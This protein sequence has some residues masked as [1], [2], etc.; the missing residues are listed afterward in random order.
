MCECRVA[1]QSDQM[2]EDDVAGRPAVLGLCGQKHEQPDEYVGYGYDAQ[3]VEC[4]QQEYLH[5]AAER[6]SRVDGLR[7]E[8]Q[9]D[10]QQRAY[11]E[12]EGCELEPYSQEQGYARIVSY[13]A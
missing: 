1:E 13:V 10:A 7:V 9:N 3:V 8:Q 4:S 6:E 12:R 11:A 5:P 2:A